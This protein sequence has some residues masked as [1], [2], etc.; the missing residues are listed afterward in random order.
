MANLISKTA[1]ILSTETTLSRSVMNELRNAGADAA[2]LNVSEASEATWDR[3]LL[4]SS[5]TQT[6]INV[7]INMCIPETGGAVGIVQLTDFRNILKNSY[8]RTWLA[9]KY[10][11][12]ALRASGGGCFINITS[13]AGRHGSSAAAARCAASHGIELMTKSA[14]LECAAK[15]DNVR[16]NALLVGDIIIGD[17]E[18]YA[19]GHVSPK[20]VATAVTHLA[21]DAALYITGLIMPVD[22]GGGLSS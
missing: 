11:I 17:H 10:G 19:P 22:N 18:A 9:L 6:G 3:E 2:I 21:S 8:V 16:V 15:Q 7:I 1:L 20:D 4:N 14:A 12:R 5:S 13:V